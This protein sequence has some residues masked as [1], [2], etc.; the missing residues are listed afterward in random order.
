[1]PEQAHNGLC[2]VRPYQLD[3]YH[4]FHGKCN[5]GIPFDNDR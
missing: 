2:N 4:F 5:N 3:E 1:M